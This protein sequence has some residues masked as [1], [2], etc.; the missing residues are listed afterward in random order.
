M[1]EIES[2][3]A[4][5]YRRFLVLSNV[6]FA[7]GSTRKSFHIVTRLYCQAILPRSHHVCQRSFDRPHDVSSSSK[8]GLKTRQYQ[9][10]ICTTGSP[11][12]WKYNRGKFS[13]SMGLGPDNSD[14]KREKGFHGVRAGKR[15]VP[16]QCP[17][18]GNDRI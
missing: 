16:G 9:S 12:N 10:G 6:Q 4:V 17:P 5:S 15:N 8:V 14:I 7:F 2:I 11:D 18:S 1:A 3:T 13:A